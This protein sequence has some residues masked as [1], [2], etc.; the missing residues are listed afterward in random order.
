MSAVGM[1][2]GDGNHFSR[3]GQIYNGLSFFTAYSRIIN[4]QPPVTATVTALG[5]AAPAPL[6]A[7]S[8]RKVVPSYAGAAIRV[9][10]SSDNAEL[11]IG[12]RRNGLFD[13]GAASIF[14]VISAASASGSRRVWAEGNSG[15]STPQYALMQ[16]DLNLNIR[17]V[18]IMS[19]AFTAATI[20]PLVNGSVWDGTIHAT[21]ST[22]NGSAISSW[23]DGALDLNA[24]GYTRPGNAHNTFAI[25]G[26]IRSGTLA[27]MPMTASEFVFYG[28]ALGTTERQTGEA[29]QKA[30]Y[31]TP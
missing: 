22:D 18:P 16:P 21:S 9:R 4:N 19:G 1:N 7:Y 8:L 29:N 17:A 31:G 25:G 24:F 6:A 10:R 2:K 27:A 14:Q 3:D 26:V 12:F 11:D 15:G 5:I 28:S 13:A 23:V 30:Y 20:Q